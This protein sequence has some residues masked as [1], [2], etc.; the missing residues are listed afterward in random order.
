VQVVDGDWLLNGDTVMAP[1]IAGY[2]RGF[3]I[4]DLG[5][6]DFEVTVPIT[7]QSIHLGNPQNLCNCNGIGFALRWQGHTVLDNAQPAWGYDPFG[8]L[9]FYRNDGSSGN[10][11]RL[12]LTGTPGTIVEDTS[13]KTLQPGVTYTFKGRAETMPSGGG[14][15]FS[16]K[17]W[18]EGQAEPPWDLIIQ[19]TGA[20][21]FPSGSIMLLS[22]YVDATFGD[23]I[24]TGVND[25]PTATN[26]TQLKTYTEGA[27]SVALDDIVVTDADVGETITARL[28]LNDV[29]TGSLSTGTFGVATSTYNSGTGLWEAIGTVTDV[30]AALA[31]AAFVPVVDN[32]VDTTITTH[33]EGQ[34]GTGPTD[35][36]ITL[37]VS[38][39]GVVVR[40]PLN[41]GSGTTA[42][43][44]S[45][46]GNNGTLVGAA[47]YN[48]SS[49]DG[50]SS[51]VRFDGVNGSIDLGL[52]DVNGKGLTL[53]AWFNA[54]AF[55]GSAKDARLI[56]KATGWQR[57]ITSSC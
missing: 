38:A 32:D 54:D 50:S 19:T 51:S 55:P 42:T 56:S 4:G 20:E 31:A 8:A 45:G 49:G 16:F 36:T 44:V 48:A 15:E 41:D 1:E 40:L 17:V 52:L 35:G 23:V 26:L 12:W 47:T 18:E 11:Q 10:N 3:A 21:D 57:T 22:H 14:S 13:G 27:S 2:D 53:A 43:D 6:T 34:E 25:P 5:W 29:A 39:L 28:T 33:V 46:N 37:D 30:N 9:A 24:V 7:I